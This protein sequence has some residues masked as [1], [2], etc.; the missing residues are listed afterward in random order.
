MLR[1]FHLLRGGLAAAVVVIALGMPGRAL[2]QTNLIV[3]PG[4]ETGD[5]TG[6][7]DT[8]DSS[9]SG[10]GNDSAL[11]IEGTTFSVFNGTYSV[12]L[13]TITSDNFLSQ[14]ITTT[15]GTEYVFSFELASDGGNPN[16]FS[17][18]IGNVGESSNVTVYSVTNAGRFGWTEFS[19]NYTATSSTTEVL[20]TSFQEPAYWGL[21]NVSV[22]AMP[23]PEP[24]TAAGLGGLAAAS[25]VVVARVRRK[26]RK[27][28]A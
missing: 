14:N 24:G 4:F 3:N 21:D 22:T 17:A 15:P 13:G 16:N 12:Y 11:V 1:S 6:W 28:T 2:G 25:A 23:V 5:F 26:S 27:T 20:F 10:V 7:S 9:Y 18:E 8:G 19:G